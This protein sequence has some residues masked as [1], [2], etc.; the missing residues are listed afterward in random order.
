MGAKRNTKKL[1]MLDIEKAMLPVFSFG[2]FL[3]TA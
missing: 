2:I 1:S 3:E